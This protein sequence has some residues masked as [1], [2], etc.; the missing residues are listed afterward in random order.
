VGKFASQPPASDAS[1]GAPS[2]RRMTGNAEVQRSI[3]EREARELKNLQAAAGD[4]TVVDKESFNQRVQQN[5]TGGLASS[6]FSSSTASV[7]QARKK[8]EKQAL[9]D[10]KKLE[11]ETYGSE[12]EE[13]Q[14]CL[15]CCLQLC[16][17]KVDDNQVNI[18]MKNESIARV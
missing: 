6:L 4:S 3:H 18:G 8:R 15:C 12:E 10:V 13:E 9:D 17:Q 7:A 16:Q 11:R 1:C 2:T 14:C 5:Q